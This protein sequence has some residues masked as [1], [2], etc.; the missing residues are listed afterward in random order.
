MEDSILKVKKRNMLLARQSLKDQ[1]AI[2][3]KNLPTGLKLGIW[4][5]QMDWILRLE[6]RSQMLGC[7]W[8]CLSCCP[9]PAKGRLSSRLGI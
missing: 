8:I 5:K 2:E 9:R 1:I 3:D 6:L 7:S 4:G